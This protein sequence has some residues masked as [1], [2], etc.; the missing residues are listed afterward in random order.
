MFSPRWPEAL[1][2]FSAVDGIFS[3]KPTKLSSVPAVLHV[4][5]TVAGGAADFSAA[6]DISSLKPTKLSSVPAVMHVSSTVAG[7]AADFSAVDGSS[8]L[9]PTEFIVTELVDEKV[10]LTHMVGTGAEVMY[11]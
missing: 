4:S 8:S 11:C 6:D 7:G 1:P 5:S 2:I 9:K 3:L 10:S